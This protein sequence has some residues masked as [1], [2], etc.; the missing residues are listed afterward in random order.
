[1]SDT[2]N[3]F[4]DWGKTMTS[5]D[6]TKGTEELLG[7]VAG[8]QVPG[9]NMDALVASQRENLQALSA[10]NQAAVA[11][12]QAVAE[13]QMKILQETMQRLT[14][15]IAGLAAVK[16]PQELVAAET[17]LARK[18]FET[19]LRQMREL[20]QIVTEANQEAAEV[21]ARRIP[22]SLEEIKDVLKVPQ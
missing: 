11:G 9:V 16:S 10:A 14:A 3:V 18:S 12:Y 15:A 4:G 17:E 19:A 6:L 1:M 13:Y 2:F 20:A 22:E 8:L 21:I 5:L 7:F